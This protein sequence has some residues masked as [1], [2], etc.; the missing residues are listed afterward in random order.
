[1]TFKLAPAG[2]ALAAAFAA[3]LAACRSSNPVPETLPWSVRM[4][5]TVLR[6]SPDP[7]DLE[8]PK[9]P[10]WE[11]TY[12][13]VLKAVL[14]TWVATGDGRYFDY[15]R[16][17]YNRFIDRNGSILTYRI[18]EYNI[19]RINPGKPLFR[20][21]RET[22]DEKYRMA[23]DTLRSQMATHPRT[24]EGGF[25]HKNKYPHQMWLD[26]IYM[27]SPFLA[28]YGAEFDEPGLLD[29]A[30][31]QVR[32][33]EKHSREEKT[34]LLYHGWDESR[35]QRWAD[36]H[37]GLSSQF[38]GRSMGWYAMAV[39]DV[40]DFLPADHPERLELTALFTRLA[41]AV[42]N[43]QDPETGLWYQVLDQGTRKGNYLES[44][45][46]C[47]FVYALAKGVRTGVLHP[48]YRH[49]AEKGYR[50]ILDRFIRTDRKGWVHIDSACAVA[51]LGGDPYRDGSYGYYIGEKI[52]SDDPK[53]VGPFILASLEM[54]NAVR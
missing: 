2:F 16:N 25:W 38:W 14:E 28:Q 3:V 24:A 17:Y 32:L 31:K 46:S 22:G 43:V 23:L 11:Y 5:E 40:L 6:R 15:V 29:E 20:L 7:A 21:Y 35:R 48:A 54:E 36:P 30:A 41:T 10:Y 26:G 8:S 52:R 53:A 9:K 39:V 51:G 49:I 1:M 50:G 34:G 45:A 4:T 27:A 18:G 13:L 37:T 47:M 12:G 19:D 33:M 44:S 42:T